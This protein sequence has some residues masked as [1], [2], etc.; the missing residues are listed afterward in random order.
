MTPLNRI[1]MKNFYANLLSIICLICLSFSSYGQEICDNRI[2]DDGDGLIDCFDPDCSGAT[3][4]WDCITEFYQV[5]SNQYLVSLDPALGT[6]TTLATISGAS[7][8]NGAQFNHVDGHVYAPCIINGQHKLGIL[9]QDGTVTDTGL[10]LPGNGI[11]YVGAISQS[12]V[13]YV[14]N[15]GG[16]YSIDLTQPT[17]TAVATGVNNPGVADF[18]LDLNNGLFY[19]VTGGAQLKVFNPANGSVSTYDIA[20]AINTESGGFGAAWS[21]NDGSFFAYNNSSG[22]I[23]SVDVYSLTST[24]VLNGTGNL[25]INDGFNCVLA[26]PPFESNCGNATDD[27]GDGLIDCDD[28]DCYNSNNCLFEICDNGIDDDGDGLIDCS[29]SECYSLDECVEICDNGIDDNNNGLVDGDDPQCGAP[30]SAFNGGLE[31]GNRLA[32]LIAKRNYRKATDSK[33]F[34]QMVEDGLVPFQHSIQ[35]S[36]FNIRDFIS[37]DNDTFFLAES[38]PTD[39][40]DIT[41]AQDVAS[42]DYYLEGQRIGSIL[43]IESTDG[44]YEHAKYICD[45]LENAVL[46]D[47]S[48]LFVEGGRVL[49]YELL[50]D[51]GQIE[52]A[53]SFSAHVS[54]GAFNME[55]HWSLDDYPYQDMYY[56]FQ[57]WGISYEVIIKLL[58]NGM[59]NVKDHFE[60]GTVNNSTLP[61]VFVMSGAYQ[62]GEL[63]LQVA[64]KDL[65]QE[66]D[67]TGSIRRTETS[68]T[69]AVSYTVP[70]TGQKE[71]VVTIPVG[72]LYDMGLSIG[73]M[74]CA[75]DAL[76]IADG[77][78]GVEDNHDGVKDV[79]FAVN[80]GNQDLEQEDY[81]LS[82][83][84]ALSASVSTYFNVFRSLDPK[85]KP[86]DCSDH[87][88]IE[89]S[90]SGSG[91]LDVTLVKASIDSWADQ[92]RARVV[93]YDETRQYS[94][95]SSDF[96]SETF[97]EVAWD[98]VVLVVF[99]IIGDGN[100][101]QPR[102]LEIDNLHFTSTVAMSNVQDLKDAESFVVTP[103]PA[104]NSIQIQG[105][106]LEN[107]TRLEVISTDGNR[108]SSLEGDLRSQL[109][110][111][112]LPVGVY[113]I[114]IIANDGSVLNTSFVKI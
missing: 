45:R 65:T 57:I 105:E 104:T 22:K 55:S 4:C 52:Y 36:S 21:S 20:G 24:L 77:A 34:G 72:T 66:L 53:V 87:N 60:I 89:F 61:R 75:D 79:T 69:E 64:N 76:F 88:T 47:V 102:T 27:D 114:K 33:Q 2:D 82:R 90:G 100:G 41:N 85:F 38:S 62:N 103:N 3:A 39:L 74:N 106:N 80:L 63:K 73:C 6:Y 46:L 83:S 5:H 43:A 16:I 13:M 18:A 9:S 42:A 94:L 68:A 10:S 15:S 56:N 71:Q 31:S 78:W 40:I 11:F 86:I 59:S 25:S 35:R 14:S 98:D 30:T 70:L 19:G 99:S 107:Y 54:D 26:D 101:F 109:D 58:N 37:M 28:P 108:V 8:I 51:N 49:C 48:F 67:L 23:Y 93:L 50:R 91:Y 112:E 84:V 111:A 12:G 17:L 29:D 1:T 44:V 110:I 113:Q 7:Q 32:D 81:G 97:G 95:H 92:P 96:T